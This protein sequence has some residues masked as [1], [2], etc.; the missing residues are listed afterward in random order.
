MIEQL[1]AA[2]M[3]VRVGISER[4][5][6]RWMQE[7]RLQAKRM[8]DSSLYEVESTDLERLRLR[9]HREEESRLQAVERQVTELSV[10]LETAEQTHQEQLTALERRITDQSEQMAQ[11]NASLQFAT[12]QV[13]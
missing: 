8:E 4:S 13:R 1:T 12:E 11:L 10:Q 5:I 6:Q 3:A 7:G 9:G 2:Q